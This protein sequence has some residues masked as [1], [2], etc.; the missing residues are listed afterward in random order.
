MWKLN[1]GRKRLCYFQ[2]ISSS[3]K[4]T[5][6]CLH[7]GEESELLN[8][9]PFPHEVKVLVTQLGLTLC[10]PVDCSPPGSSV[11]GILQ[12]RILEWVAISFSRGS[13][14]HRDWIRVSYTA[15]KPFTQWATHMARCSMLPAEGAGDTAGQ[16]SSWGRRVAHQASRARPPV[17]VCWSAGQ[18]TAP[19]GSLHHQPSLQGSFPLPSASR[20]TPGTLGGAGFWR[21]SP[22]WHPSTSLPSGEPWPCLPE[23]KVWIS[24]LLGGLGVGVSWVVYLSLRG[25]R[26]GG[27]CRRS[28]LAVTCGTEAKNFPPPCLLGGPPPKFLQ[29]TDS[30]PQGKG[31]WRKIHAGSHP[32]PSFPPKHSNTHPISICTPER[33]SPCLKPPEA[34]LKTQPSKM[35]Q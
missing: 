5:Q 26:W 2:F 10:D 13:S 28:L 15:G 8:H 17:A 21:V 16:G 22:A 30:W 6:F 31:F 14:R 34:E 32:K 24:A 11:H 4:C 12:A 1:H 33:V 29:K 25:R 23:N 20:G 7:Y 9:F 35:K 3:P 18:S 19:R 27:G